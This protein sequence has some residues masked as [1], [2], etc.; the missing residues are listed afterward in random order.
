MAQPGSDG[1]PSHIGRYRVEGPLGS[2]G[3]GVIYAA[4]D[5]KLGRRVAVKLLRPDRF[6]EDPVRA[7]ERLH[8]EAQAMARLAHPNVVTVFDVG[9]HEGGVY[10]AM[11]LVEGRSLRDWL[12]DTAR[13]WREVLAMYFQAGR[14]LAA[15]HDAGLVHRDFKPPNVLVGHDGRA[16]VV[17]FGLASS[18]PTVVV[19]EPGESGELERA[20]ISDL[21][22]RPTR[23]TDVETTI[24]E[25]GRV[26]SLA[27]DSSGIFN[28][29]DRRYD[30]VTTFAGDLTVDGT[31]QGLGFDPGATIPGGLTRSGVVAGTPAYMAPELFMGRPADA[32]S[33]QFA[34]CVALY[35]GLYGQRPFAGHTASE[36]AEE[37]LAGRIR[38]PPERTRV[39]G[40]IHSIVEQGLAKHR[41][42]RHESIRSML[43]SIAF[44]ARVVWD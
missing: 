3:V 26:P 41:Q 12:E 23:L 28:T 17:D 5:P 15:A 42:D 20:A 19:P 14:G 25:S 40:W 18:G 10:I 8:E 11:E 13:P 39:P 43:A 29:L 4:F 9:D 16:R 27:P 38:P 34:Y 33:D 36:I 6:A 2:G 37:V 31:A 30:V 44:L 22:H 1:A 35:E 24:D 21:Y 7:G 32:R